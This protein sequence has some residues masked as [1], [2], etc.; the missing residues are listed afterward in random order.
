MG[1]FVHP[2]SVGADCAPADYGPVSKQRGQYI[3]LV[4]TGEVAR[5]VRSFHVNGRHDP[6]GR[7]V[8]S[9][10]SNS[11]SL[12]PVGFWKPPALMK[13]INRLLEERIRWGVFSGG[14][15]ER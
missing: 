9:L 11:F 7:G 1:F 10:R 3:D 5:V 14:R 6:Q 8:G 12:F 4:E 15:A 13:S 2:H